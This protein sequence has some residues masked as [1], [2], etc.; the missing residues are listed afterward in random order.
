MDKKI[1]ETMFV[2]VGMAWVRK[3]D[4]SV[5]KPSFEQQNYTAVELTNGTTYVVQTKM[6]DF[7]KKL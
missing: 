7:I 3:R 1:F 5:I 6:D 4:I 2:Q